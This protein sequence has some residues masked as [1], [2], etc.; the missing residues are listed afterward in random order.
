MQHTLDEESNFGLKDLAI[1]FS[2]E[3]CFDEQDAAN[4]E[5]LELEKDV[6][7]KGGKWI[8][9]N[10][11]IY[12]GSMSIIGKYCCADVDMTYRLW[13]YLKYKLHCEKLYDFFYSEEVM[14][15]YK[16]AT[17]VMED[18]GVY[19]N[20]PML[21]SYYSQ[22]K[23]ELE[24][25][26][27]EIV[28]SILSTEAGQLFVKERLDKEFPIKNT[29]SFAQ[30]VC[31]FFDLPLPKNSNN[32][33][34]IT[35]KTVSDALSKNKDPSKNRALL[36]LQDTSNGLMSHEIEE[37]RKRLLI[38]SEGTSYPINISSK[39]QLGKIVFDIMKIEPLTKTEKGAAQ[40]NED[41]IEHLADSHGLAWAKELRVFNKLTKT[42]TSYY[43]RY[44]ERQEDGVYYPSFKQHGTSSGRFSSDMQQLSRP[45]EEGSDDERIVKYTNTLREIFIPKPGY[46]F[47]DDDY[48]SL[49]PRCF[50]DDAS[51]KA[52][53]DIFELGED[54]YS[55]VA[56]GAENIQDVSADKK[57]H[58]FLKNLFPDVRQRAKVYSL[59]IRYGMK[60][61][62]LSITL[63]ISKEEAQVIIDNYFAAFPGLKAA[64]DKYLK[65]AKLT[66]KVT[67]KFGRV[68]HLPRVKEI[69][70]K[71]GD[72]I[73]EYNNLRKISFKTYVP[74]QD[75]QVIRKEYNSLLNNSLNF[76]I[77]A[78]AASLVNRAM[79]AIAKKFKEENLDA[80][81]SLQIHDQVIITANKSCID[82]AKEIVQDCMENTNKLSMKLIAKPEIAENLRDGH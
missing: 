72:D 13:F 18:K 70:N 52:L 3:L 38:D 81:L 17:I 19:I 34:S 28:E 77:Q 48:E 1:R 36:F 39:L 76:P 63:N 35:K 58:N 64:M 53:I 15:L 69:Y 29:G 31:C 47:I 4:Q 14:P 22:I 54:F 16:L 49:E 26:E 43:E 24:K 21:E 50:A 40:F 66:G 33:Y 51:D 46:L 8:K 78:T 61:G 11:E 68:R 60:A 12:K 37:I 7:A 23:S 20:L 10:K 74:I 30:E 80:W 25:I 55:K 45:L 71:F 27:K 65:E 73:L 59:G 57:A 2:K 75:L 79:I 44:L 56:I 67:S 32:K 62:K 6:I 41:M 5:Q 9:T 42:C 82:R